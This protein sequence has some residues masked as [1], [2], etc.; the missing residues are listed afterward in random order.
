MRTRHLFLCAL[1]FLLSF[2]GIPLTGCGAVHSVRLAVPKPNGGADYVSGSNAPVRVHRWREKTILYYLDG[3]SNDLLRGETISGIQAWNQLPDPCPNFVRTLDR[4]KAMLTVGFRSREQLGG[5]AGFSDWQEDGAGYVIPGS[6]VLW[7][8][9]GPESLTFIRNVAQ[10]EA[11]HIAFAG[12]P[13]AAGKNGA[14][15]HS[16]NAGDVLFPTVSEKVFWTLSQRD[17]NSGYWTYTH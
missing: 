16:D 1:L 11:L 5:R 8:I 17:V 13:V 2:N 6:A 7:V 4:S 3:G 10:H 9:N 15:D 12:W 14:G